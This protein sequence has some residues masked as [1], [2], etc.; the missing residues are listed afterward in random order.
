M[1]IPL[2]K[3][4]Y[5][6]ISFP[7]SAVIG[8]IFPPSEREINSPINFMRESYTGNMYDCMRHTSKCQQ[9]CSVYDV[10][11]KSKSDAVPENVTFPFVFLI[12]CFVV[13]FKHFFFCHKSSMLSHLHEKYELQCF[14]K[15]AQSIKLVEFRQFYVCNKCFNKKPEKLNF[16]IKLKS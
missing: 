12:V 16:K 13:F 2:F 5:R 11:Q 9:K 14:L 3:K 8:S 15:C 1:H 10:C 4:K 6:A 7:P